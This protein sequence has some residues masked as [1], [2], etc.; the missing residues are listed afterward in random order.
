M[1]ELPLVDTALCPLTPVHR[2]R[3]NS[4]RITANLTK[5]YIEQSKSMKRQNE[6][7]MTQSQGQLETAQRETE[8][9]REE[10]KGLRSTVPA[11]AV[12]SMTEE[13]ASRL[14]ALQKERDEKAQQARDFEMSLKIVMGEKSESIAVI[15][16]LRKEV[17]QLKR[18]LAEQEKRISTVAEETPSPR[19]KS[20]IPV[21]PPRALLQSSPRQRQPSPIRSP[22]KPV[23]TTAPAA[24]TEA[25]APQQQ[26]PPREEA[27][28]VAAAAEPPMQAEDD[29]G[30]D[31]FQVVVSG[32]SNEANKARV[33]RQLMELGC[34]VRAEF[35]PAI[36]HIVVPSL[37]VRTM[38][39]LAGIVTSKW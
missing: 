16:S 8:A 39:Y 12:G 31:H 34:A 3:E 7:L 37:E 33:K 19:P 22:A 14:Q 1:S 38:N 29:G 26:P 13:M 4:E 5:S 24:P 20:K 25:E 15:E 28:V 27:E 17:R 21:S 9:L 6:E 11:A 30:M 18:A 10:L 36:T 35:D 32:F 2:K 23:I